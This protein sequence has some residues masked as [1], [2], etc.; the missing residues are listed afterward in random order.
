MPSII[1][2]RRLTIIQAARRIGRHSATIWRW[3]TQ[4]VGGRV[5]PSV[6][7]GGRLEILESDLEDFVRAGRRGVPV[8]ETDAERRERA[9]AADAALDA[10]GW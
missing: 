3:C 9:E 1:D 10:A 4:G 5:L 8:A 6:M 2:S 7:L